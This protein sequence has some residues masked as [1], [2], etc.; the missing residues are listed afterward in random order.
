MEYRQLSYTY[1]LTIF[2][3]LVT[4]TQQVVESTLACS[5]RGAGSELSP[6]PPLRPSPTE[7]DVGG[8]QTVPHHSQHR[9]S[10]VVS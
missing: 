10:S 9:A 2:T 3:Y 5:S 8:T 4:Y 1:V 7:I 6:C